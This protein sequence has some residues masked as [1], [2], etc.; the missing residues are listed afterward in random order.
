[1]PDLHRAVDGAAIA[2]LACV[3]PEREILRPDPLAIT[4][5]ERLEPGLLQALILEHLDAPEIESHAS[6]TA[7]DESPVWIGQLRA[8]IQHRVL[9]VPPDLRT[10]ALALREVKP[11]DARQLR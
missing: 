1:M 2:V 6:P 4:A 11:A 3:G 5:V 9:D 8:E 10:P 7:L